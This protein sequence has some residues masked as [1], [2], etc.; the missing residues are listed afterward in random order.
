PNVAAV[1]TGTASG[2]V[3]RGNDG[4]KA[5]GDLDHTDVDG[6]DD[7]WQAGTLKSAYGSLTITADGKWVYT[8]DVADATVRALNADETLTDSVVVRSSDG[9]EKTVKITINGT[10]DEPVIDAI[11]QKDLNEQT[12]TAALTGSIAVTFTDVDLTDT[13]HVATITA[14]SVSAGTDNAALTEAVLKGL[15]TP[16]TVTKA[17]GSSA[18]SV[19]LDFSAASTV[20]DYLAAGESVEIT[21]TVQIDDKE[22]VDNTGTQTFVVKISGTNDAPVVAATDV[23]GGVTEAVTPSGNLT[24]TGT[25]TFT[26]VDLTD[27]HTVSAVTPSVGALG[28]LTASVTTDTTG[29][30]LGGVVTWNYSVAAADV[31]YLADGETKTETFTF[32][33]EDGEGGVIPRTVTVTI[34]GTNDVPVIG[35][36][37]DNATDAVQEDVDATASGTLTIVDTDTGESEFTE[38]SAGISTY[39][40]YTLNP[41]GVWTYTLNNANAAVQALPA[42]ATLTDSFVAFSEDGSASQTVTIT[43]TGTNDVPVITGDDTGSVTEKSGVLNATP[44]VATATGDLD[45]TDVDNGLANADD[46]WK[47]ETVTGS[48]GALV[49]DAAGVWTY[50]LDDTNSS[51]Q[52]LNVG[53]T[54]TDTLTLETGDGT[55]KTVSI[56]I[57]GANDAA[58]ATFETSDDGTFTISADDQD[59]VGGLTLAG[60]ASSLFD[61]PPGTATSL[62]NDGNV[63]TTYTVK[64]QSAPTAYRVVVEDAAGAQSAVLNSEGDELVVSIGSALRNTLGPV[65]SNQAAIYYGFGGNDTI[66]AGVNADTLYGGE[67]DDKFVVLGEILAGAFGSGS[68]STWTDA[69]LQAAIDAQGLTDVVTVAELRAANLASEA[70]DGERIVGG[71]GNDTLYVFGSADLTNVDVD[72]SVENLVLFSRIELTRAQLFELD[73]ITLVGNSA[74]TIVITDLAQGETPEQAF[75]AWLQQVGQQLKLSRVGDQ[76]SLSLTIGDGGTPKNAQE[77]FEFLANSGAPYDDEVTN[78]SATF[79]DTQGDDS[80]SNVSGT[81]SGTLTGATLSISGGTADNSRAGFD[82]SKTGN[83]GK[84]FL[85]SS[86]GSYEYVPNDGAIEGRTDD[87]SETFALLVTVAGDVVDIQT[88]TINVDGVNDVPTITAA[89]ADFGFTEAGNAAAQDL[90]QSGTLGFDD[91]DTNDVIDVASAVKTGAV[92][93]GGTIDPALK[94]L[95]EGG[96]SITGTDEAAPGSVAWTY[97]VNDAALDFLAQGESITLTYT[98]TVTDSVGATATDD[99]TVTIT[100]TNDAPTITAAIADFGFTEAGN[101]AAQ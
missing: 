32:D 49:I 79:T 78:V 11:A 66:R 80:F 63:N 20:F 43:I 12:D 13:G 17:S 68:Y 10:N 76:S 97:T 51:V 70:A 81:M 95:L 62:V 33:I 90:S 42:G 40:T 85:N 65:E 88:L 53:D 29:T 16:G 101:A 15:V 57:N 61:N 74:H 24:D 28:T 92:W 48:Y 84:L 69:A 26:D 94:T 75:G 59:N 34:T 6:P 22:L 60:N 50:T 98:V 93:S 31:E 27:V 87:D 71:A 47:A 83:Y 25:I 39:G 96:F 30:G 58:T 35:G 64:S 41:S 77:I 99:V 18:G 2:T 9:T 7:V 23:T 19:T 82:F 56:T 44:G 45:H 3:T 14:A 21:Y 8:L 55:T 100:G 89:I 46:K 4:A 1:I 54:L 73:T 67:G 72:A 37:V 91:L 5:S 38:V 36:V 86:T 52:A